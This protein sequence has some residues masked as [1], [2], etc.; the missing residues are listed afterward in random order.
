MPKILSFIKTYYIVILLLLAGLF[1]RT[2][3]AQE[4]F[5]YNHDND[6]A[7]WFVRDVVEIKHL[8]LIGQETSTKGIFIGPLFY[9]LLIP[10]YLLLK[11]D[12]VGG[13]FLVS[14]IGL[15]T[16]WSFY[17]VFNNLFNQKTG[18]VA[19]LIYAFSFFG[20][21]NDR[22]VVP[23]MPVVLWTLWF[24]Y[25]LSLLMKGKQK[26]AYLLVGML[27]ALIWHLNISLALLAPLVLLAQ[28]LSGRSPDYR[29]VINGF[30]VF[31]VFSIPLI[32]F[33]VRHRFQQVSAFTGALSSVQ[34]D[35]Y[36]GVDKI[37]RVF[38]LFSKNFTNLLWGSEER[39]SYQIVFILGLVLFAFLIYKKIITRKYGILLS[40]WFLIY[41]VFFALYSKIVS[42][43]YL[44]GVMIIWF[45]FFTLFITFLLSNSKLK[46]LGMGFLLLY[47]FINVNRFFS[48]EINRSGYLERKAIISEI[49]KDVYKNNYQCIAISYITDPGYDLGYRYFIYLDNLNLNHIS[50]DIPIYTIVFPLGKDGV[51]SDK[52]FGALGLIYPDYKRYSEETVK[53]NCQK[54]N[55]NLTDSMFGFTN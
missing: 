28:Y 20:I 35:I 19:L 26:L 24:F 44:D 9:Y 40:A 29:K 48:I 45:T 17:Y 36:E 11:M 31:M 16:M 33:E 21:M 23:T 47:V 46:I 55:T 37:E 22:W 14:L 10:F 27:F 1:L 42:E 25:T 8:R 38:Y 41:F 32:L 18:V 7:G 2:Y 52:T 51:E 6:L 43:Y 12:P 15:F 50:D 54:E 34:G 3:Q 4:L 39:L 53:S 13:V 30:V 49:K 5:L